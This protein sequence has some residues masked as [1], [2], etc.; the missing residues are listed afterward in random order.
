MRP[1]PGGGLDALPMPLGE[2]S[3]IWAAAATLRAVA[4]AVGG[5]PLAASGGRL[6]VL[7]DWSGEAATAAAGELILVAAREAAMVDR[8]TRAA[9]VLS[10]YADELDAAQRTAATLQ[11]SWDRVVP[12]D[13]L[14]P[15][16]EAAL[17]AVAGT[18]GAMSADLQLSADVAAHRL[19]A[20]V[21][22]VV[23][24]DRPGRPGFATLGW[25]D[26]APSVGAVR[27]AML[28]GLPVVS[29]AV[30]S[31]EAGDVADLTVVD[32]AAGAHRAGGAGGGGGSP[33]G[34]RGWDPVAAQ[35]LWS[36]L[37][38]TTAGRALDS[39]ARSGDGDGFARLLTALGVAMATAANPDYAVGLDAVT[40]ARL[41]T[42][43]EPWLVAMAAGVASPPPGAIV[44]PVGG[45][46]VQGRLLTAVRRSGLSPGPRYASTVAVAVVAAD[47]AWAASES[48]PAAARSGAGRPADDPVVSVAR[49][50]END[51]A[52]ARAWLLA[53][54]PGTDHRLVVEQ[55]VAGRYRSTDPTI[56]AAS[57]TATGRLVTSAGGEPTVREAVLLDAAFLGALGS[58]ARST[59]AA[60]AYRAALAPAL[61]DVGTVIARHPDALTAVLDDSAGHGVDDGL[62]PATDRLTRP[63]RTPGTWE[64]VL[65]DRPT[66]AALV[67][68]LAFDTGTPGVGQPPEGAARGLT[69]SPALTR[70]LG[71]VGTRLEADLVDAVRADRWGDPHALD[72]ASRRLGETV[73]FTLTS[74]GEG[75]ARRDADTDTRNRLLAGLA[76][77]AAAKVA[78]PGAGS[79][80]TPLVRLAADR[81]VDLTLPTG[82]EAAQRR[83]TALA[84]ES[85]ADAATVDVR[86]L[87]S[88]A[89]P[90]ADDEAPQR[91]GTAR[92][93]VRFWDE[94]GTPLPETVM[95]TEQRRAF[96]A[97]RRERGLSVYDTAPAAV[98]DSIE[99]GVR[100]AARSAS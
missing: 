93:S 1:A 81:L 62:A 69:A 89:H 19:R 9:A 85:A 3:G 90:W 100:A 23:A 72:A 73:G 43:R 6:P 13:P 56:A 48:R 33:V 49:A 60:D 99:A 67:G 45:A 17:A 7:A 74:A 79:A 20:L 21:A 55:L 78:L 86:T 92:G 30:G 5:A 46:W 87:V 80:A 2:P 95:T 84:T 8:L 25:A 31:R 24:V 59:D 98:R 68:V 42:W 32:L 10:S 28:A 14:A 64:A 63:G 53:P 41:D 50:L 57:L 83:A 44:G 61:D 65:P 66:T 29:G 37:D 26:P 52:A 47:R 54:L 40:R 97:W 38:P 35:A 18:Y 75:L 88:R 39:L 51:A 16:P 71:S 27:E 91:W 76:E 94:A 82:S 12:S 11:A 36:R 34:S 96:T 70:V 77:A 58:E 22:E 4:A 15:L